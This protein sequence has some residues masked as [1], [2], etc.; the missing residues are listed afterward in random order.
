MDP[1]PLPFIYSLLDDVGGHD[2]C[3][4][5]VRFSGYNWIK[6]VEQDVAKIDFIIEWEAF[7]YMVMRFV[8]K[9]GIPSFFQ[10][11]FKT[12]LGV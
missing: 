8:L 10:E 5:L 4:F 3:S 1:F 2:M 11:T 9:N 7:A 12:Q 6:M